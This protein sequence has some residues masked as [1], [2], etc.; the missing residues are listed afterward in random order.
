MVYHILS[1]RILF[2]RV[3]RIIVFPDDVIPVVRADLA[4]AADLY[5]VV[6]FI[7]AATI[8]P[9]IPLPFLLQRVK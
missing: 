7:N 4:G 2:S 9:S 5:T 8:V 3:Y 6:F 1:S